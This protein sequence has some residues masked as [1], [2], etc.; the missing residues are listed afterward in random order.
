MTWKTYFLTSAA[1]S[2]ACWAATPA[3]A[4]MAAAERWVAEEFDDFHPQRSGPHERNEL[5]R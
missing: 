1:V 3:M 4:D 2:L 5:V